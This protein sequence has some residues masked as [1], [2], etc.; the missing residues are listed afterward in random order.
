MF[1]QADEYGR[2]ALQRGREAL[3]QVTATQDIAFGDD[4]WQKLDVF[5]PIK[6]GENLPVLLFFHG[7]GSTHG[8]KEWCSFMAPAVTQT[9]AIFVSASYRLIPH[10]DYDGLMADARSALAWVHQN[11][12]KHGGDPDRIWVGGHSAGGQISAILTL[13]PSDDPK[14]GQVQGCFPI[15]GTFGKDTVIPKNAAGA[16]IRTVP[17]IAPLSLVKQKT[18]PFYITWGDQEDEKIQRWGREMAAA[19]EAVGTEAEAVAYP[20]EDHF[21][22]HLNTGNPQDAWTSIVRNWMTKTPARN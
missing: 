13:D 17:I 4:Y 14:A 20:G 5:A 1:A 10:A 15:S 19:L 18:G 3:A 6:G 11:I 7:G 2:T 12:A 21:T 22:I 9:P 8:Y 16:V